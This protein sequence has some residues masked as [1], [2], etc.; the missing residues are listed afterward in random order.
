MDIFCKFMIFSW[1]LEFFFVSLH[2]KLF[3]MA[4]IASKD[5][6][7]FAIRVTYHRE[8][9]VA[10]DLKNKGIDYFLPMTYEER[11]RDER[12]I[13]VLI[14]AIHNLIFIHCTPKEMTEYKASTFLPI[15]YIMDKEKSV[16]LTIPNKQMENFIRVAGCYNEPIIYLDCDTA[17]LKRGDKVRIKG[18]IFKNTIGEFVRIRGDRRVLVRIPGVAAVATSFVHPS[19]IEYI[20]EGNEY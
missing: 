20:E 19:L 8:K 11:I 14:P 3:E 17:H 9:K 4:K 5:I 1:K 2:Y 16:P 13:K 10:D 12:R 18:G 6:L 15:R 7:W